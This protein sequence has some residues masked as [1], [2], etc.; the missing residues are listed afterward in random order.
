MLRMTVA[1]LLVH[2]LTILHIIYDFPIGI[3]RVKEI[4]KNLENIISLIKTN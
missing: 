4:L 2:F 3:F 1:P